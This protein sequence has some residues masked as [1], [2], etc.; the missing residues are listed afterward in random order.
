[1][2]DGTEALKLRLA[3]EE[4]GRRGAYEAGFDGAGVEEDGEGEGYEDE[5]SD[6]EE[7]GEGEGY[8]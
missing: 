8:E 7:E 3:K 4:S 2:D 1:M 5:G 6:G